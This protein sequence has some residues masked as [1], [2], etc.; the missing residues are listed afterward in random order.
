PRRSTTRS[1]PPGR[2]AGGTSAHGRQPRTSTPRSPSTT[3]SSP[4]IRQA[5]SS[6][7]VPDRLDADGGDLLVLAVLISRVRFS[8]RAPRRCD[9]VRHLGLRTGQ[10]HVTRRPP[11]LKPARQRSRW[12]ESKRPFCETLRFSV[13]RT[14]LWHGFCKNSAPHGRRKRTTRDALK[15]E[16]AP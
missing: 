5:H 3:G 15:G 16:L 13:S 4:G 1:F 6:S 14:D 12:A 2:T 8:S 9:A 11:E 10:L 7:S